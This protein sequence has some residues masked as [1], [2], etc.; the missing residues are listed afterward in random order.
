MQKN[1]NLISIDLKK[2]VQ[3]IF[4]NSIT[5]AYHLPG[6]GRLAP[7]SICCE[8]ESMLNAGQA[9]IVSVPEYND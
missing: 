7:H 9:L 1:K 2:V 5:Y 6:S 3:L 8:R 4:Q